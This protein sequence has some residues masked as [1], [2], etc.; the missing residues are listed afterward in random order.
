M[1]V[2]EPQ[3]PGHDETIVPV[4]PTFKKSG[5]AVRRSP[6]RRGASMP[7]RLAALAALVAA[8]VAVF[9]AL[10]R[11]V[12]APQEEAPLVEEAPPPELPEEQGPGYTEE[13]LQAFQA[14]ADGLL[15]TLLNQQSQ[16]ERR[17]AA[18]W[19]GEDYQSYQDLARAGDDAYLADA[20][21]D[22]VDAYGEALD[23]G[24]ALLERS[25]GLIDA[26]LRAAGE[27]LDA[28]NATVAEEQYTL[29]LGIEPEHDAAQSGLLRA[30]QLP[31]VLR[32]VGEG[33]G[34]QR[35]G[36]LE[37]AVRAYREAVALDGLWSPARDALGAL[38]ARI[39]DQRFDALMSGGLNAMAAEDFEQAH[40]LFSQALELRPDSQD[41]LNARLQAEQAG[42][43]EQ[44]ALV[45]ARGLAFEMR[46]RWEDAAN[47][48]RDALET[49][50]TLAFAQ[51]GLNRATYRVDLDLKLSNLIDHPDLLFD[52]DVLRDAQLLATEAAAVAP[53]G[54]RLAEQVGA[55]QGL[56]RLA[57]TPLP[58]RLLSDGQTEVT[59]YRVG[60]LEPFQAQDL[61]LRP[62][63][64][65][66][67]GSRAGYRDV[68]ATF[69]VLPGQTLD[70]IRV[71]CVEPIL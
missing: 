71:E 53:S 44:I 69:T 59:L 55:L 29:V 10:P 32:R 46:E 35:A 48:Y 42:H 52:D 61:E 1:A 26:A 50:S 34:L 68:R 47:Q 37:G 12:G 67:V 62:G 21:Y 43:L 4:E 7:V 20:W 56:L 36:D 70:P 30:R 39:R 65:T 19:A 5:P 14:E 23:L 11:W 63:A 18:E 15:A 13:E 31:E 27:A 57:T 9:V 54:P 28:G 66:A 45:E 25:A 16:L 2:P 8:A 58:V 6:R 40:E 17:S 33:D 64:Y 38:E 49:D 51:E 41:A 22:S 3:N 60:R 24:E